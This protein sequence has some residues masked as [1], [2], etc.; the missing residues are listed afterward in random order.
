[1]FGCSD[2]SDREFV[3]L[4][5]ELI[6]FLIVLLCLAIENKRGLVFDLRVHLNRRISRRNILLRTKFL[7]GA[8]YVFVFIFDSMCFAIRVKYMVVVRARELGSDG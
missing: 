8:V 5:H 7:N 3:G 6:V 4:I 1:M 2:F